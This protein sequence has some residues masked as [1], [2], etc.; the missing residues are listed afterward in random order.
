MV[1]LIYCNFN[2]NTNNKER[3]GI[4][5]LFEGNPLFKFEK[6][7]LS[8]ND[9]ITRL[10]EFKFVLA[11]CGNG[12]DTHRLWEA[13]YLG[14]IPIIRKHETYSYLDERNVLIVE[15]YSKINQDHLEKFLE[16][17]QPIDEKLLKVRWWI[18]SINKNKITNQI[19]SNN[20][21]EKY[22]VFKRYPSS[23]DVNIDKTNGLLI[24][25]HVSNLISEIILCV[26]NNIKL[27]GS[28]WIHSDCVANI[29]EILH[30]SIFLGKC[31]ISWFYP[32]RHCGFS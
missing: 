24:G 4:Y 20:L 19:N 8:I 11:P 6:A 31:I 14:A 7:T 5:K 32:E 1:N 13:F 30:D 28:I 26:V 16:D 29:S 2:P 21:V 3:L 23:I 9:Y 25:P 10:S 12:F 27:N 18:D 22:V 17:Y 15:E